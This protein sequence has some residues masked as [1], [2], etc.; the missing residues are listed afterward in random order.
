[1]T[2]RFWQGET[3][4][5]RVDFTDAQGAPVAPTGVVFTARPAGGTRVTGTPVALQATGAFY[6]DFALDTPGVWFVRATCSGPTAA[7]VEDQIEV[8]ASNV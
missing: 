7:A 2:M 5:V 3:V 4:R 1:M 6:C 8:R